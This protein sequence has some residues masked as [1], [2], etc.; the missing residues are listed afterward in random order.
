MLDVYKCVRC[1][2]LSMGPDKDFQTMIND[3]TTDYTY[4]H[5]YAA[6]THINILCRLELDNGQ[7]SFILK[8]YFIKGFPFFGLIWR[9]VFP[10]KRKI[11]EWYNDLITYIRTI[12]TEKNPCCIFISNYW[13]SIKTRKNIKFLQRLPSYYS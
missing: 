7:W 3:T 12:K 11:T 6:T 10:T 13:P 4:T 9:F 2:C 8:Y 1:T 5:G